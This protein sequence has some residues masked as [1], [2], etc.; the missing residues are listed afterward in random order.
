MCG[1]VCVVHIVHQCVKL[2]KPCW[3]Y[4]SCRMVFGSTFVA[5]VCFGVRPIFQSIRKCM[6]SIL[7]MNNIKRNEKKTRRKW[8]EES[9]PLVTNTDCA[10]DHR[11]YFCS[12]SLSLTLF[13]FHCWFS[14]HCTNTQ[15]T[16]TST[17]SG[18][19]ELLLKPKIIALALTRIFK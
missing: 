2:P 11:F 8:K 1:S 17:I 14:C 10:N 5:C 6:N 7:N 15:S 3:F 18:I 13:L 12:L 19:V 4:S 16:W 9:N